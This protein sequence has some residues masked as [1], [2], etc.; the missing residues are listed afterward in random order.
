M[1]RVVAYCSEVPKLRVSSF[2]EESSVTCQDY[3]LITPARNEEAYLEKTIEAVLAQTI[4]PKKWIIVSDGSVDRT[5]EI[6]ASYARNHNFILVLRVGAGQQKDFGSK[7][8]AFQAGYD[9]LPNE[10]FGFVGNLDADVSF[11][12]DYY[13]QVLERLRANPR[14]GIAGGIIQERIGDQFISQRISLNSVAGAVQLFRRECFEA[15]GGYIPMKFG[16]IDAAAEIMARMHGWMVQTF[17]EIPVRHH[18]RVSTGQATVFRARFRQGM[19]NYLLGYH[20]LFQLLSCLYRTVDRPYLVG[21]ALLLLG[22]GWSWIRRERRPIP[23]E[24]VEFLRAEQRARMAA[25]FVAR[26]PARAN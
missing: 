17:P 26:K 11:A 6:A 21:S 9:Q 13:Q 19:T 25:S 20:P 15:I 12:P 3:V 24:V 10:N 14:L 2:Y 4:R 8:R 16:G 18:R 22:Y 1:W 5:D 7:V 23:R